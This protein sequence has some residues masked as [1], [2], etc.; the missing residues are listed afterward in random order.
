MP[1]VVHTTTRGYV[2][3]PFRCEHCRHEDLGAVYMQASAAVQTSL[4]QDLDDSRDLSRGTAH[5]NM[6]EAGD[7]LVALSPC[8]NCGLRDELAVKSHYG[9]AKPWLFGGA[10]FLL[11]GLAGLGYTASKGDLEM[12][13]FATGP[14]VVIGLVAVVVGLVK[15]LRPLPK[16]AVFRSVDPG[17]WAHLS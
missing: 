17:P 16:S 9:K 7:A 10:G 2:Y 8:P 1:T 4:L 14:V 3:A 6:E 15:R 5:G 11:F 12:G 13:M